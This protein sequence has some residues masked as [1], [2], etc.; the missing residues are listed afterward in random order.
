[1][2]RP[3]GISV[4][5]GSWDEI[6]TRTEFA[7]PQSGRWTFQCDNR[8]VLNFYSSRS[9]HRAKVSDAARLSTLKQQHSHDQSILIEILTPFWQSCQWKPAHWPVGGTIHPDV[10]EMRGLF[11]RLP[12]NS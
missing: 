7:L 9:L 5:R 12:L 2:N 4:N 10:S 1:M 6:A 3:A 8:K 11:R